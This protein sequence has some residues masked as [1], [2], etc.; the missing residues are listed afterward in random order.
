MQPITFKRSK[1]GVLVTRGHARLV[2]NERGVAL[3]RTG[4]KLSEEYR[5]FYD[6]IEHAAS[7]LTKWARREQE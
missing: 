5:E 2:R 7:V 6:S 1:Q 4:N 3:W